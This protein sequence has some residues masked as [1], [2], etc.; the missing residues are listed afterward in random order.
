MNFFVKYNIYPFF[1]FGLNSWGQ[2]SGTNPKEITPAL[3]VLKSGESITEIASG[4][5][6][7]VMLMTDGMLEQLGHKLATVR[8][9]FHSQRL[10]K[11][12]V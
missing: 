9:P 10:R 5:A 2:L 7:T 8:Q 6:H 12:K 3:L 11:I 4:W 1:R